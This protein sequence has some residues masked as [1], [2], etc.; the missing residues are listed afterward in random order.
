MHRLLE[1]NADAGVFDA[2]QVRILTVAFDETWQA[3]QDS[4]L[5]AFEW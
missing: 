5:F 1:L 4:A 3:V 2:E